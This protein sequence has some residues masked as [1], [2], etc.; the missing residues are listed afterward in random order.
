MASS[1]GCKPRAFGLWG[2]DSLSL[3]QWR[4]PAVRPAPHGAMVQRENPCVAGRRSGFKSL[5]LHQV[6]RLAKAGVL[7]PLETGDGPRGPCGFDPYSLRQFAGNGPRRGRASGS[8][9]TGEVAE[10]FMAPAC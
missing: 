9:R 2:F 5:P 7:I 6:R 4:A 1:R 8:A 10:R 3:Y